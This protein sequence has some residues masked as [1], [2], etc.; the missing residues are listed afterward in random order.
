MPL[1]WLARV[2]KAIPLSHFSPTGRPEALARRNPCNAPLSYPAWLVQAALGL[3]D[4]MRRAAAAG[5]H[6]TLGPPAGG[7]AAPQGCTRVK[8]SFVF[9]ILD[10]SHAAGA[11]ESGGSSKNG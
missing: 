8:S 1:Q 2:V 9:L 10:Q 11:V 6:W 5:C 4:A 3:G 7:W